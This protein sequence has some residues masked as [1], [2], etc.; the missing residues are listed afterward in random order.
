MTLPANQSR[1]AIVGAGHAG[2]RVAQHLRA[3]GHRGPIALI[4]DEKHAPYERPALSKELLLGEK[5]VADLTL[6]P[7]GF[8]SETHPDLRIDRHFARA[9]RV[10]TDRTELILDDENSTRILFDQLVIATG[11]T[12]RIPGIEGADDRRI[13][14]LRTIDDCL[15]LREALAHCRTIAI[16]GGG[17]IGMEVAAAASK[18]GV[19]A[20]VFEAADRIMSRVLPQA[21]SEWLAGVHRE[22]GVTIEAGVR[23]RRIEHEA[24]SSWRVYYG[25]GADSVQADVVLLAA[26]IQCAVDFLNETS[27]AGPDGILVDAF[28]RSPVAPWCY[29]AGDVAAT[30]NAFYGQILRQ[31]T[32]RNAENQAR[33]VAEFISGRTEPFNELP[34]MWTDQYGFNIQVVGHPGVDDCTVTRGVLGAGPTTLVSIREGRISGAVMINQGRERRVL[35]RLI[36][37]RVTVNARR[38]A[39]TS[40]ALKEIA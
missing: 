25:E 40:I 5:T 10:L 22:N 13:H 2:G 7:V 36:G 6:A 14:T 38:M 17:V 23:V 37:E 31:E 21:A 18:L 12:A 34:W 4:G 24:P 32:W 1:V 29:A 3:L 20:T 19:K 39:D 27:I 8:W 33:A 16:V 11:G 35:E 30:A 15:A 9:R 28:C 26:G